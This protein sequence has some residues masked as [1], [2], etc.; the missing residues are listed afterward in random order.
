MVHCDAHEPV[1]ILLSSVHAR[2]LCPG[3]RIPDSQDPL[4]TDL[5]GVCHGSPVFCSFRSNCLL[6]PRNG[7]G[8]TP[9]YAVH[10]KATSCAKPIVSCPGAI[11]VG[12]VPSARPCFGMHSG[13]LPVDALACD[14]RLNVPQPPYRCRGLPSKRE[15][16]CRHGAAFGGR[17]REDNHGCDPVWWS[18][19]AFLVQRILVREGEGTKSGVKVRFWCKFGRGRGA[20]MLSRWS[21]CTRNAIMCH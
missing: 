8:N 7:F 14:E 16:V 2:R 4:T 19:M 20:G 11:A 15:L 5:R 1:R 18:K 21:V 9:S 6:Q 3:L 12:S 10:P 17:G 13:A